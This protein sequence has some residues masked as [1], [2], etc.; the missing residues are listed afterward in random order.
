MIRPHADHFCYSAEHYEQMKATMEA[1]KEQGADGFVFG[2]LRHESNTPHF[3]IDVARNKALVELA[4]GRPCTFHRAFDLIPY[5]EWDTALAALVEC[6]FRSILTN[7]GPSGNSAV[8]CTDHLVSLI[9]DQLSPGK[10]PGRSHDQ[11]PQV[12]VGGGVRSKNIE[13]LLHKT[14]AIAFHS[15]ALAQTTEMVCSDEVRA[16]RAALDQAI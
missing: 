2:I 1:F 7:G 4:G 3:S 12:I 16:L 15:A 11:L 5:S 8:E 13:E 10:F 14:S 6:G 9:H